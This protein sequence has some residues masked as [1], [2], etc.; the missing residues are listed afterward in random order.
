MEL[1]SM[2]ATCAWT[3]LSHDREVVVVEAEA[4]SEVDAA[5]VAEEDSEVVVAA[6]DSEVEEVVDV[7]AAEVRLKNILKT[8]GTSRDC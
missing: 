6:A 1:M 5:A 8:I 2:A 4:D 7:E 3:T